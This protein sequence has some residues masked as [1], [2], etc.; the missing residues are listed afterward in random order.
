MKK[1]MEAVGL[2]FAAAGI[3]VYLAAA[4]LLYAPLL[5][6]DGLRG[7]WRRRA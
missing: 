6:W 3:L 7:K 5:L 2:W 1:D 4:S